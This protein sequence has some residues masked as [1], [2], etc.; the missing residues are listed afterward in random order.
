MVYVLCYMRKILFILLLICVATSA[1]ASRFIPMIGEQLRGKIAQVLRIDS[2]AADLGSR[3]IY[4]G[5]WFDEVGHSTNILDERGNQILCKYYNNNGRLIREISNE[6]DNNNNRIKTIVKDSTGNTEAT[7][8]YKYDNNGYPLEMVTYDS[9]DKRVIPTAL[10]IKYRNDK[11]MF[12]YDENGKPV[13]TVLYNEDNST[14]C[15]FV[16]DTATVQ[17]ST[18]NLNKTDTIKYTKD[19]MMVTIS[20][21]GGNIHTELYVNNNVVEYI[22]YNSNG[23][24]V[25][26]E[27]TTYDINNNILQ[28]TTMYYGIELQGQKDEYIYFAGT[29]LTGNRI[30]RWQNGWAL[31]QDEVYDSNQRTLKQIIYTNSKSYIH[32]ITYLDAYDNPLHHIRYNKDGSIMDETFYRYEDYDAEGNWKRRISW[33]WNGTDMSMDKPHSTYLDITYQQ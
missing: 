10:T 7:R 19:S 21:E 22:N 1:C 3:I 29:K 8:D 24:T 23:D 9:K 32:R 20:Y 11:R 16:A 27:N 5:N 13:K 26:M 14:G 15:V 12:Y 33:R 2:S 28:Y 30:Y 6:Y 17:S 18:V 31:L 4:C 25:E